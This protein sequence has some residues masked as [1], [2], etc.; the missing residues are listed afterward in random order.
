MATRNTTRRANARPALA[1]NEVDITIGSGMSTLKGRGEQL[2]SAGVIS[3]AILR[4]LDQDPSNTRC[5][6]TEF[7]GFFL[8]IRRTAAHADHY[9]VTRT[10]DGDMEKSL[11]DAWERRRRW[12]GFKL[13]AAAYVE[14]RS[15]KDKAFQTF[16]RQLLPA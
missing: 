3:L 13:A 11:T 6:P 10:T 2:V 4:G 8:L 9:S 5:V 14:G 15:S 7:K 1:T 12:E 16:I